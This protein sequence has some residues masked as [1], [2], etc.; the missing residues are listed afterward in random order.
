MT[1]EDPIERLL[2]LAGTRPSASSERTSRVRAR[3]HAEWTRLVTARTRRRRYVTAGAAMALAAMVLLVVQ[4]STGRGARPPAPAPVV[5]TLSATTGAVVF[6]RQP[7]EESPEGDAHVV[8]AGSVIHASRVLRTSP[9]V[10]AALTMTSG[11]ALRVDESTRLRIVS[12]SDVELLTGR[13]YVETASS[14]EQT[15]LRIHTALGD[16]HDVGTRFEVR[17]GDGQL[18]V[19][20]RDGEVIVNA[21][22]NSARAG[23]G[24][25]VATG[26]N[27]LVTRA[28][29]PFGSDWAWITKSAPPF[30]LGG[31][32]LAEFLDWV[33]REAGYSIVFEGNAGPTAEG[34]VL[35]GS[36]EDLTPDEALDVVVPS[37]GL[38][39]RIVDGRVIVRVR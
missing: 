14:R 11:T 16:V 25:E 21:S 37:T 33:S 23:S 10:F 9:R 26:A 2:R 1:D 4:Y 32:T 6:E 36:I 39:H 15:S 13:V 30:A 28:A 19:R 22:G 34:T 20:V 3:A 31:R 17:V 8:P 38:E 35:Q 27:G 24:M 29:A 5:A 7:F 18:R 12:A